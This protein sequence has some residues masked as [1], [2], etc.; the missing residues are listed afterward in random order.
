[1]LLEMKR[2]RNAIPFVQ[3]PK[4]DSLDYVR[5]LGRLYYDQKDHL[6]LA[7]KA[8]LVFLDHVRNHYHLFTNNLDADF[9]EALHLKSGYNKALLAQLISYVQFV[10]GNHTINE[11]QL[12]AYHQQLENFYQN[13]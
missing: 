12:A 11:Q 8:T 7:Q 9:V 13:T 6:N 10:Q 3:K 5:T 1:V 2:R 4:N